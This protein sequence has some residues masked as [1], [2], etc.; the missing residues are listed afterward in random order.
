MK[1]HD[2]AFEEVFEMI[3]EVDRLHDRLQDRTDAIIAKFVD[4]LA[5]APVPNQSDDLGKKLQ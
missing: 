4:A 5:A 3:K 1:K 2:P